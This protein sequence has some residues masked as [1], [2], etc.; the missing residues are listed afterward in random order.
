MTES[1]NLRKRAIRLASTFPH[2]SAERTALLDA[3]RVARFDEDP[4]ALVVTDLTRNSF[5]GLAR[6][7]KGE[8]SQSKSYAYSLFENPTPAGDAGWVQVKWGEGRHPDWARLDVFKGLASTETGRRDRGKP[9][10]Y[11]FKLTRNFF[12]PNRGDKREVLLDSGW[13]PMSQVKVQLQHVRDAVL[14][15]WESRR[16]Y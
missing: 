12:I 10:M 14:S 6:S 11:L 16:E 7:L 8:Y 4:E 15:D 1:T 13:I 5:R 2:K 9:G 3:L